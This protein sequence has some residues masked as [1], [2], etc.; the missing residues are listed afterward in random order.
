MKKSHKEI[1][2]VPNPYSIFSIL[3]FKNNNLFGV[4]GYQLLK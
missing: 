1:D 3:T 4:Y 2:I